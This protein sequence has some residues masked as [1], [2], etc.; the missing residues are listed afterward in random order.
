MNT[1]KVINKTTRLEI[2]EYK[3]DT[4]LEWELYPFSSYDHVL[5]INTPI[6]PASTAIVSPTSYLIDIGPFFDRFGS[7]KMTVLTSQD[8]VI[9]AILQDVMI[10]KWIDL[11]RADV[12]TALNT[13]SSIIPIVTPGII[14]TILNTPVSTV[15]NLALTKTYFDNGL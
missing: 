2:Y 14:N 8:P 7:T 15:E 5:E 13:I 1:Y 3:S 6:A 4:P 12:A 11:K 9:K 10:R